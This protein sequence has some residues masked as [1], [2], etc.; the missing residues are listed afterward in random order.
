MACVERP[1]TSGAPI[2]VSGCNRGGTT[3]LSYLLA[4]HPD[5]RSVGR[6]P[7]HEGQYVWRRQFPDW[8]RHRWALPP[9]RWFLR[10]TAAHA[11]PE[12]VR[13]FREAFARELHEHGRMLEK[14][15]ANAV[16]IPFIDALYPDC[17][18]VHIVRDG[19]HTA[20]S[21]MARGVWLPFAPHQW[22]QAHRTALPDLE[23][24]PSERVVRVRYE[25][26]V[27]GTAAALTDL[28]RQCGLRLSGEDVD[29]AL[30]AAIA[31]V[32]QP[33][34]RWTRLPGWKRRY[35]LS[36]IGDLQKELGYPMEP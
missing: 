34:D 8:S 7:F 20:A 22:V 2:F 26:L 21:L 29:T 28:W 27:D 31:R 9:W 33:D 19:R 15:P 6:G 18:F 36:V 30:R 13:F 1:R 16:R 35:I 17:V 5:V 12:R 10:R 23:R 25:E 3:I 14:T 4:A 32:E 24:L 11:T